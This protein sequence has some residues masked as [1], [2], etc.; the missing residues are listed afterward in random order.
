MNMKNLIQR[1]IITIATL[2]MTAIVYS[3]SWSLVWREDFG[4]A[5]DTVIKNFADP[6][7]SVPNHHFIDYEE[8]KI[9]DQGPIP[10]TDYVKRPSGKEQCGQIIDGFYGIANSTAW[11]YNRFKICGG[12]GNYFTNGR[13][14]TGNQNGAML[15]INSGAGIGETIYGQDIDFDLCDAKKYRFKI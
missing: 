14:H 11:S 15:I 12:T 10:I 8:V 5:E 1:C 3:Q 7:M 13:D 9:Y 4:V 6:T 2:Q